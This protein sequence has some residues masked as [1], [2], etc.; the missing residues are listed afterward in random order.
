[1]EIVARA[2]AG[3][4]VGAFGEFVADTGAPLGSYG[5][6][7]GH[8]AEMEALR[9]IA[10]DDHRESVFE[11]ERFGDVEIEALGVLLF[12]AGVDGGGV[13]RVWRLVEDGR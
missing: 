10:A 2:P 8:G 5:G 13:V 1:M 12:D 11:A 9:V 3:E 4:A 7:V 6:E